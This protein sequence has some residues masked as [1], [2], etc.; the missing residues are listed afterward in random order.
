MRKHWCS[1]ECGHLMPQTGI[2][3]GIGKAVTAFGPGTDRLLES[4]SYITL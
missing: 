1:G 2:V 4:G 3:T